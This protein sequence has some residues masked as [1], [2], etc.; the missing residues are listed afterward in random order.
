MVAAMKRALVF[1]GGWE[2]H[3][4]E[5]I[6][7]FFAGEL[8]RSGLETDVEPG[9]ESLA[10]VEKLR[11]YALI[12]P[13]VTMGQLTDAQSKGLDAAVRSGVGLGGIHG[14]MGDAFRS[15]L[16]YQWMV[17][18][19]FVGHPHVGEYTVRV[20]DCESSI[21]AGIPTA[22]RYR[23]EQYYMLVDP[24]VHVLADADYVH[25]GRTVAMPVAWA[26]GWGEGRVFYSALGHDPA[27]FT[28]FPEALR[29]T[30]NGLLWAAGTL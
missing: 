16:E 8:R 15:N 29:L 27:E 21:T 3:Q 9:V 18:G 17:G 2:G 10:D 19:Q 6:A 25:E 20:R 22:F 1:W 14:G 4:P 24:G 11:G 12:F 5:K 30:M 26:K 23:S 28:E 7:N 13:C